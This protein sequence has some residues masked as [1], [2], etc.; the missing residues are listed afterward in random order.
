MSKNSEKGVRSIFWR[1]QGHFIKKAVL[2][3]YK[4]AEV[5]LG[6]HTKEIRADNLYE[7]RHIV[8][9]LHGLNVK[10]NS[11]ALCW[12]LFGRLFR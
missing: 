1:N 6:G 10:G 8:S 7:G 2:C 5:P 3:S 9:C 11:E 4:S 12:K